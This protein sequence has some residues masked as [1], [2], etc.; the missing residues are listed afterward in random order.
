MSAALAHRQALVI[1]PFDSALDW[2]QNAST[3]RWTNATDVELDADAYAGAGSLKITLEE[4]VDVEVGA[5][6]D[7]HVWAACGA[8][9]HVS[10]ACRVTGG[11]ATVALGLADDEMRWTPPTQINDDLAWFEVEHEM[12]GSQF[13]GWVVRLSVD[14][15]GSRA[16][17]HLDN[18]ACFSDQG[19]IIGHALTL[20]SWDSSLETMVWQQEF[21]GAQNVA[22]ERTR[23][24]LANGS[25]GVNYTLQQTENW[26]GF[27]SF[28]HSAAGAAY[29]NLTSLDDVLVPAVAFNVDVE[30]PQSSPQRGHLRFILMDSSDCAGDA[31]TSQDLEQY[32]SFHYVLDD[33]QS[34]RVTTMLQGDG[35]VD[36]PFWRTGW[37]GQVGNDFLDVSNIKGFRFELNIDSVGE[38]LSTTAGH[39]SLSNVSIVEEGPQV[40]CSSGANAVPLL[41]FRV[42]SFVQFEFSRQ[43][44]CEQCMKDPACLYYATDEKN[45]YTGAEL[46]SSE[47]YLIDTT[48]EL[49]HYQSYWMPAHHDEL[50]AVCDCQNQVADC[51][52]RDHVSVPVATSRQ[53]IKILDLSSNPRLAVILALRNLPELEE[54]RLAGTPITFIAPSVLDDAPLV[55]FDDVSRALNVVRS[56]DELYGHACCGLGNLT[57]GMHFCDFSY[58]EPGIDSSYEEFV[59]FGFGAELYSVTPSSTFLHEA[60]E[61]PKKCAEYCELIEECK[62]WTIDQRWKNSENRCD[63]LASRNQ[64]FYVKSNRSDDYGDPDQLTPGFVSGIP[65][66]MRF[67]EVPAFVVEPTNLI[68]VTG[69]ARA[70]VVTYN[71][72]LGAPPTRGAV[73]LYPSLASTYSTTWNVTFEPASL[74]WYVS[75]WNRSQTVRVHIAPCDNYASETL[76]IVHHVDACDAAFL[77]HPAPEVYVRIDAS[78]PSSSSSSTEEIPGALAFGILLAG[79]SLVALAGFLTL[80]YKPAKRGVT[81]LIVALTSPEFCSALGVVFTVADV[82]TDFMSY[83]FVVRYDDDASMG[84]KVCFGFFLVVALGLSVVSLSPTVAS[85]RSLYAAKRN[86][87]ETDEEISIEETK[88]EQREDASD[89]SGVTT[90]RKILKLLRFSRTSWSS[91]SQTELDEAENLMTFM[92]FVGEDVPM[93]IL[94]LTYILYVKHGSF[95]AQPIFLV[96]FCLTLIVLGT[97]LQKILAMHGSFEST[98]DIF[99][100]VG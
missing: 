18:I 46:S 10:V 100:H 14:V 38:I 30:V 52:G 9:T 89:S 81:R 94:N 73:R 58:H 91:M 98:R 82:T 50:C 7:G 66:R 8:A 79:V 67:V 74:A 6:L 68:D 12:P 61:S 86:E 35:S 45:C 13:H 56:E 47:V 25:M 69:P 24:V 32:Y 95:T 96:S 17:V 20:P 53:D 64:T 70:T 85:L 39:I 48:Y 44:C 33:A 22:E 63:L 16:V 71:L 27:M 54:V 83:F 55:T 43:K 26:G 15:A 92:L 78:R 84:F 49:A 21:Y 23:I 62:Y 31:C 36:S 57:N 28:M 97:K 29:Y 60:A 77:A 51:S 75:T 40:T 88:D 99:N 1:E 34:L 65:A 90:P 59:Q 41:Q 19:G 4:S 2:Q 80:R 93:L 76:P 87:E 11:S 5:M 3:L 37:V 72:T 42:N